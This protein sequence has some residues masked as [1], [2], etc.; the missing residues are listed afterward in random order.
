MATEQG[1]RG[2]LRERWQYRQEMQAH[3]AWD[4]WRLPTR[5]DYVAFQDLQALTDILDTWRPNQLDSFG[6][7]IRGDRPLTADEKD[8]ATLLSATEQPLSPSERIEY[9]QL[10]NRWR[11]EHVP[12]L[13]EVFAQAVDESRGAEGFMPSPASLARRSPE[14]E[15]VELLNDPGASPE[16]LAALRQAPLSYD[17]ERD[18]AAVG[19]LLSLME[20]TMEKMGNRILPE[21]EQ[22]Q[23]MER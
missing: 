2:S 1:G 5:Q 14:V 16:E 11:L 23:G 17:E 22:G 4:G 3:D 9:A 10:L 21:R 15:R 7:G 18:V 8:R 20:Q 6:I 19:D 12:E 13:R